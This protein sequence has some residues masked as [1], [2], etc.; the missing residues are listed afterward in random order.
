MLKALVFLLIYVNMFS[1]ISSGSWQNTGGDLQHSGFSESQP[2]PLKLLW[3]YKIGTSDIS[4]PVIDSG[5]LF[6][7][8]DDNN[9]YAIDIISGKLKWKYPALGKVYAPTVKNGMVYAGSFDNYIYALDYSM[10]L[11]WK[12]NIGSSSSSPPVVYSNILYGGSGRNIYA[13]YTINGTLKWTFPTGGNVESSPSISQGILYAGSNDNYIYAVD[14]GNKN[15]KWKFKTGG[16][17]PSSPSVVNGVVYLASRDNNVYAIDASNGAK[18]WS[19]KLNDWS[20]SALAVFENSIYAGS[21]DNSVYSLNIDNGDMLWKFTTKGKV[22]SEFAVIRDIIYVGSEDGIVYALDKA[23][24]NLIESYS[25]GSG[26]ISL[27][28]SDNMLFAAARDGHIY[29]FGASSPEKATE[30]PVVAADTVPP[31]LK[32]NPVPLNVTS[33]KL[34]ISG[35]A[36]DPSGILVVTVNGVN[37]GASEWNSTI[38]L[39]KG[40]NIVTIVAVDRAGNIKT[41]QRVVTY[42]GAP[43]VSPARVPGSYLFLTLAGFF[44]AIYLIKTK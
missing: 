40:K 15:L 7:G 22:R 42:T 14:A 30:V 41:E 27:A 5:T 32:I 2:V 4:A 6:A 35:T 23:K 13:I 43:E 3:D 25:V 16:G 21:N 1:F 11:K 44:I 8:S 31:E 12:T 37:A 18:K 28:L 20:G 34:T 33:E 24:G 26:I 36:Q 39:S 9:L 17:N 10:N 38:T 29:A 19:K